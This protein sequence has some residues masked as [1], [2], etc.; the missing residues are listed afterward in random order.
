MMMD[1]VIRFEKV[2]QQLQEK[3]VT[4]K[5]VYYD[6]KTMMDKENRAINKTK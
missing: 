3:G 6:L 1:V 5:W 2:V 4:G